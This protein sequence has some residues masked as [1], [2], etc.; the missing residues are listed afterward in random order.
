M[1]SGL[2]TLSSK[3]PLAPPTLMATSLPST[4][5]HTMVM[6]SH[7]VGFTL[8]GMMLDPG[9][10][11]G[12]AS[13]PRP[14]R[15]PDPSQRR[16]LASFMK[17]QASVFSAPCANTSA[18]WEASASNLLGAEWNAS[19]DKALILAAT[20][21]ANLGCV[22]RPVPTAVPPCA[23]R[24]SL[25]SD[26]STRSMPYSTWARQPENSWPNVRGVASIRWVRPTLMM[27][28]NCTSFSARAWWSFLKAGRRRCSTVSTAAMCMAVGNTSLDDCDMLTSSFGWMGFL[29]PITPP[30]SSIARLEMTSF[31]FMF[32]CV[33]DP[34]CHTT[35][36][37]CSSSFPSITSSAALQMMEH[38]SSGSFPSSKLAW[39]APFFRMPSARMTGRGMRSSPTGKLTRERCVCAPQ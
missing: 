19:P 17:E 10:F 35:R 27:F 26:C 23:R 21:S 6:L 32:V 5:Q 28:S 18:S 3:A 13:S 33:P 1:M 30:S 11:S 7:C 24:R 16:S 12:R 9:S 8:P 38:L 15:G 34:V 2:N 22:L 29:E 4:W 25:P 37:K 36:G 20:S 39:A 31:A 14:Q